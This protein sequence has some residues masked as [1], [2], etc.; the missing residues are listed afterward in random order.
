MTDEPFNPRI[1]AELTAIL[2]EIAGDDTISLRPEMTA[3]DLPGFD[4]V[5]Q[6]EMLVEVENRFSIRLST[7]EVDGLHSIGDYV[8]AI[9]GKIPPG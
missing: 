2:R 3:A 1:L 5:R 7:R 9:A 6:I 4:S 8:R